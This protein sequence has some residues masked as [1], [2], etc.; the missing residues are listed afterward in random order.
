MATKVPV[1]IEARMRHEKASSGIK[2]LG[3]N[4]EDLGQKQQRFF[5]RMRSAWLGWI[6]AIA[7]A[8]F[9]I[10]KALDV[11]QEAA[12][13]RQINMAFES[14]ANAAGA[15]SSAILESLRELSGGTIRTMELI[16]S[17]NRAMILGL[18]IDKLD[19]LMRI[20]RASATATGQSVRQMF[21]DIVVGIGRQSRLIL[22]NL[23]IIVKVEDANAQY[24]KQ[25][26]INARA[27]TDVQKRQAFL[28]AVLREGE[29]IIVNVGKAG[30][31]L[32]DA[33]R[34]QRMT[35]AVG[36]VREEVGQRMLPVFRAVTDAIAEWATGMAD[37]L[38]LSRQIRETFEDPQ[39][40][41]ERLQ[42]AIAGISEEQDR[43]MDVIRDYDGVVA[44]S[45]KLYLRSLNEERKALD[46]QL[47]LVE[48]E[49]GTEAVL[50]KQL[51]VA[52][53]AEAE[54]LKN[55]INAQLGY[56]EN[57]EKAAKLGPAFSGQ[58]GVLDALEAGYQASQKNVEYWR[59]EIERLEIALRGARQEEEKVIETQE[60]QIPSLKEIIKEIRQRQDDIDDMARA[61]YEEYNSTQKVIEGYESLIRQFKRKAGT[62][63]D[64]EDY[65]RFIRK[66]K[67]DI[68]EK[69]KSL[70]KEEAKALK[71]KVNTRQKLIEQYENELEAVGKEEMSAERRLELYT[72]LV[73]KYYEA[74]LSLDS[75]ADA[76]EG[77]QKA[78]DELEASQIR[79]KEL[80]ED[81]IYDMNE[82]YYRFD[83]LRAIIER[84]K[85][86]T[87][88]YADVLDNRM[89]EAV[90]QFGANI[91]SL[92]FDTFS[93]Q[94]HDMIQT[95]DTF[96]ERLSAGFAHLFIDITML[97]AKMIILQSLMKAFPGLG[98]GG[99]IFGNLLQMVGVGKT[100]GEVGKD[101]YAYARG[102]PMRGR[103]G[104]DVNLGLFHNR[105]WLVPSNRVTKATKPLLNAITYGG[106]KRYQAGGEVGGE[107]TLPDLQ[108]VNVYGDEGVMGVIDKHK[109]VIVNYV[110]ADLMNNG[111]TRR[112]IKGY[113]K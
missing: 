75:L 48:E 41:A 66:L 9:A 65:L 22:D 105:E 91:L 18:P 57:T 21:D 94:M 98:G 46:A 23:G 55:V 7:A 76:I 5:S 13:L 107:T 14:M 30:Q 56:L 99:G 24:A 27:L 2:K 71:E 28:N 112:N 61:N 95:G 45:A 63:K 49:L 51:E 44:D 109:K 74:G 6:A 90:D 73:A 32:T 25:L 69:T 58:M 26:G 8:G 16:Q 97:I 31:Q 103:P 106:V 84:N 92:P 35:A 64:E 4:I 100:G 110:N 101:I 96:A 36:R 50:A 20:A 62:Y 34:W 47:K 70:T 78:F 87:V 86:E 113:A 11:V 88:D 77:A 39:K 93:A 15:S 102:G 17:A 54:A 108:I 19:Q 1:E 104:G 38:E 82:Y 79:Q 12:T 53:K 81:T 85:K 37:T 3:R 29:R 89:S 72:D 60:D 42:K 40:E 83:N 52:R 111:P 33:E 59:E 10:K 67:G 43:M 68:V 80:M